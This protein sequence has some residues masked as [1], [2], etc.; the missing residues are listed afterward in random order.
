M[1]GH[2]SGML[3]LD[4]TDWMVCF[5]ELEIAQKPPAPEP[6]KNGVLDEQK[7]SSSVVSDEREPSGE[8]LAEVELDDWSEEEE[9][10]DEEG[11]DEGENEDEGEI[12]FGGFLIEKEEIIESSVSAID[13]YMKDVNKRVLLSAD[14]ERSLVL[15]KEAGCE[16]SRD[17]L[18]ACNL[19]LV[20]KITKRYRSRGMLIDDLIEE[21]NIGLIKAIDRFKSEAGCRVSTYATWWI[22]QAIERALMD[23]VRSI[24]VPVHMEEFLNRRRSMIAQMAAQLGRMPC[25]EELVEEALRA[26]LFNNT[27]AGISKQEVEASL[28]GRLRAAEQLEVRLNTHSLDQEIFEGEEG[29]LGDTIADTRPSPEDNVYRQEM[30]EKILMPALARLS[31][32][33]LMVIQRRFGLEGRET[34]TLDEIGISLGVTRERIRQIEVAALRKMRGLKKEKRK[35]PRKREENR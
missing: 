31:K 1:K 18:I 24:R 20:V 32:T 34:E 22:R 7:K 27:Q 21:G 13:A 3:V 19:R 15:K 16:K 9:L 35:R 6:V 29:T 25:F 10:E 30:K 26:N 5:S 12:G 11:D 23:K 33:E 17:T 14:E 2:K 28:R 8:E 4:D